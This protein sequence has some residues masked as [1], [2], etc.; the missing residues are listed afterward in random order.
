MPVLTVNELKKSF[1]T[2]VLF[3][4][5]SFEVGKND[6]IGL[7]G[8]NG[9]GKTT[10]FRI[11]E[12]EE[13]YDEGIVSIPRDTTV[14]SMDQSIEEDT[15]TL[16]DYTL[17]VFDNLLAIE[18]DL[19]TINARLEKGETDGKL[20]DRQ[21]ALYER[22]EAAGGLT[23][24]SRTRSTLLGL[25]FAE[26]ELTK[27][28]PLFSGGQKNKAQLARVLLS[29]SNLLLLDEP[30][31][32]LDISA[33]E[34]LESFLADY[35]G[36]FIV[37]SHDRYFLDR[38]TNVTFELKDRKLFVSKGNY[39][40]HMELRSTARE[41]ELK[42]Y[43]RTKKEISRIEG[44][45]EQQR[46]WGQEH[47][48]ITAASKQKAADRLRETLVEP[49][50][51]PAS[52][53]F[54][55]TAKEGGGSEAAV[56]KGL[57]KS[58]GGREVFK[59]ADLL[60]KKGEKVFILGDN[61]C[62]K[63]TLLNILAGRLRPTSGAAYLGAHTE[64]AYYEQ[65]M[66]GLDTDKTVLSEVWDRYFNT[67]SHKDIRNALGAFL[68][69]GDD[70]EKKVSMLSGGEKARIQ[71]L[72]LMLTKANLLLL[73]EP[74][75]H[76]DIPSREALEN[77]LDEYNGTVIAVTHDRYLVNRLADRVVVMDHDGM[78]EYVGGYDDYLA[79]REEAKLS[80]VEKEPV[81][82]S[83]N[84]ADYK[85]MKALKSEIARART[86]VS[87][88]EKAI[89]ETESELERLNLEL[90]TPEVAFD[91]VRA[92]EL[93]EKAAELKRNAENLFREWEQASERLA[94][95]NNDRE[96]KE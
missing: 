26:D 13:P 66:T 76:L 65:T 61:G 34:W 9:C 81:K 24:R 93:S 5:I 6:H 73:D 1:V 79:A 33:I 70:V 69:R 87:R 10:L 51:D 27:A 19:D 59:N 94:E 54:S 62:G 28:I 88:A 44:M 84:A 16:F 20:L 89:Q 38:V 56:I 77:A 91:Y 25:G 74:T 92:G 48:F 83:Q 15:R 72:K 46:R 85:E 4:N 37:I 36:A 42:R 96:E 12:G 2:R 67:I 39:S 30:T 55:F 17:A 82:I 57:S 75:N 50:R 3:E 8:V 86:A 43:L 90:S 14:G 63:T 22:Y 78:T 21:H 45:V 53:H 47:N 60:V 29:G 41:L 95:L 40:R 32:H 58:F 80:A 49:E 52:I 7:I 18:N 11:I 68:F 23:F 64:A 71:L 31:N 35:P